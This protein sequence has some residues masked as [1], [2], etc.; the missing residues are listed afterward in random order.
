MLS[1]K[2]EKRDSNVQQWQCKKEGERSKARVVTLISRSTRRTR[3]GNADADSVWR[4]SP[5]LS[6]LCYFPL[7]EMGDGGRTSNKDVGKK[8]EKIDMNLPR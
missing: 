8:E 1:R 2:G 7:P 6:F 5:V 4:L 3:M